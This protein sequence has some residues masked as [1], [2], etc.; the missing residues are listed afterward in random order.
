LAERQR[1]RPIVEQL[2]A[3]VVFDPLNLLPVVGFGPDIM[4]GLRAISEATPA[5]AVALRET[6][7]QAPR[8]LSGMGDAILRTLDD[9]GEGAPALRQ[10]ISTARLRVGEQVAR[11]PGMG[12]LGLQVAGRPGV[13]GGAIRTATGETPARITKFVEPSLQKR[14][15]DIDAA[16]ENVGYKMDAFAGVRDD[17][18]FIVLQRPRGV[19]D[20]SRMSEGLRDFTLRDR[21]RVPRGEPVP[22][23]LSFKTFDD[24][25]NFLKTGEYTAPSVAFPVRKGPFKKTYET[26]KVRVGAPTGK[27]PEARFFD[28]ASEESKEAMLRQ[29]DVDPD[30]VKDTVGGGFGRRGIVGRQKIRDFSQLPEDIRAKLA[31]LAFR[32]AD[33]PA[34]APTV[35]KRKPRVK[36]PSAPARAP[37]A[38]WDVETET[39]F[40]AWLLRSVRDEER[41]AV[42]AGIKRYIAQYPEPQSPLSRG[43]S[44]PEIRTLAGREGF[45]TPK[46]PV[47]EEVVPP[48]GA[49]EA[50]APVTRA[51]TPT[52]R[53]VTT[54]PS[55]PPA[56]EAVVGGV[57]P[58]VP[59]QPRVRAG[60]GGVPPDGPQQPP[61][62]DMPS[63][64]PI[65]SRPRTL[66]DLNREAKGMRAH[67]PEQRAAIMDVADPITGDI[68]YQHRPF[69]EH[70]QNLLGPDTGF[71]KALRG[72]PGLKQLFG[73]WNPAQMARDNP[74]AMI[75]L[76]Q[77]IFQ[78]IE[79]ARIRFAVQRWWH[80][81]DTAFGFQRK[82]TVFGLRPARAIWKAS[83]VQPAR[84]GQARD[85]MFGTINDLMEHPERYSLTAEQSRVL[86]MADSTLTQSVRDA[87]RA[88]VDVVELAEAYWPRIVIRGPKGTKGF[89]G[90]K[91]RVSSAKGYTRQR[92]FSDIDDVVGA[93]YDVETDPRRV[94]AARLEAGIDTI[95]YQ[96]SRKQISAL[97]GVEKPLERLA[98][99]Y[100][101]V[102]VTAKEAR[103]ARD[104]AKSVVKRAGDKVTPEEVLALRQ[105]EADYITSMR[106]VF[107]KKIAA[108]QP[109]YYEL[110]L[111]NGRIAPQEMVEDVGKLIDL[112]ELRQPGVGA[113]AEITREVSQLLRTTLTN[114]DI[115]AGFIQGQNLFWRNNVA[116]WKAQTQAVVA[117]IDDPSAWVAKN[118]DMIDE[119][120]RAGAIV[121]PTEFLFAKQGLAS[122]PLRIP[123]VGQALGAFNRSFEWFITAGQTE[124]YKAARSGILKNAGMED[125]VSLGSAIR[126]EVGT[127]SYAILGVRPNQRTL[128]ALS[129]FAARFFRAN[130]GLIGQSF[131]GGVGGSEARKALGSLIAGGTA[132]TI[133]INWAIDKKLPNMTDP[134]KP[135]WMQWRWGKTYYNAFGPMYPYLR[136]LARI[137]VAAEEGDPVKAAKE[138]RQFLESKASL[139]VRAVDIAGQLTFYGQANVFGNVIEKTPVGIAKGFL[140]EFVT[141]ISIQEIPAGIEEGRPESVLE[142]V[143]LIGRPVRLYSE[144]KEDLQPYRDTPGDDKVTYR[145]RNPEIDAKLF[146]I[147]GVTSLK[148]TNAIR[149]AASLIRDNDI[150]PDDIK[151]IK[152]RK[153][154]REEY[155][156]AGR[157]WELNLVDNLIKR[158]ELDKA[159]SPSV[160]S[161]GPSSDSR[162]D[163]EMDQILRD[164][165]ANHGVTPEPVGV[166]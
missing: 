145:K 54:P 13:A 7:Q 97:P 93:G 61:L 73:A 104:A 158:L 31:R 53:A 35:P 118:F 51:P 101:E 2:A 58:E 37:G 18:Y 124:L 166:R 98:E 62:L 78:E 130:V 140:E 94:F 136:V 123:Y 162:I 84:P 40:Q 63:P 129:L 156:Q 96:N 41:D 34:I 25:D 157:G 89:G 134:Y 38:P 17:E 83:N 12:E 33:I 87:Q 117:L 23:R 146:I 77:T 155:R 88:G 128:E 144:W 120:T 112:P 72:V 86:D 81:A 3:G 6:I 119:G 16:V 44:W 106:E 29:V 103:A 27:M 100:P 76:R 65:I 107:A 150:N 154:K 132:L 105:A 102:L 68:V 46:A 82:S 60:A 147:G 151:A 56:R 127:E 121:A 30:A 66:L 22:D 42:E 70:A 24:V 67:T 64:D 20:V 99:R 32:G 10:Q 49:R 161:T 4:R 48:V 160:P 126:K 8:T 79:K 39:H 74:I 111:P 148:S 95:A 28:D 21:P 80:D 114:V 90:I 91:S 165:L 43:D 9:L 131:T 19:A 116:W 138:A 163:E 45:I 159:T 137:G 50:P 141:P 59:V 1:E 26:A 108:G 113:A 122:I 47:P 85:K 14:F 125:L 115:A 11:V 110:R 135:D 152:E 75:G 71:M 69:N 55:A 15:K 149:E 143:G 153:D 142:F 164:I 52:T 133:G 57:P 92:A 36:A 5:A 139:P 109:G